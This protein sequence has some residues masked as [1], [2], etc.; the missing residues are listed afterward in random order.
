MVATSFRDRL[1]EA[2]DD[3]RLPKRGRPKWV[4]VKLKITV[5]AAQKY[6]EGTAQPKASRWDALARALNVSVAWLRDGVG[7]KE[8]RV[9]PLLSVLIGVWVKL[10]DDG[11]NDVLWYARQVLERLGE[12]PPLSPG[13]AAKRT[14]IP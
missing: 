4:S 14:T 5:P 10:P 13:A 2:M 1:T 11:R 12:D 8:R 3:L 7:P 6:F 9:D